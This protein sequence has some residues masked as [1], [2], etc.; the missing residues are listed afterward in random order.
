MLAVGI[1]GKY[2]FRCRS[3]APRQS[4]SESRSVS[5]VFTITKY[6]TPKPTRNV[7]RFIGGLIINDDDRIHKVFH[8]DNNSLKVARFV[9]RGNNYHSHTV[10]RKTVVY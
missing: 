7:R 5:Q 9:P 4:S 6:N 3:V 2:S 10:L 8:A 1:H